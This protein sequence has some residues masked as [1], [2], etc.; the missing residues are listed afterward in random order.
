MTFDLRNVAG[1]WDGS[2]AGFD[3]PTLIKRNQYK[4]PACDSIVY[5]R[6][7]RFCGVCGKNLPDEF[8]F[9]SFETRKVEG[10]LQAEK[11]KHREWMLKHE[12]SSWNLLTT[13]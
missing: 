3:W 6:K 9:S 5:S 7:S 4:C 2:A 1:A 13:Q 10:L 8:L 12:D 11:R